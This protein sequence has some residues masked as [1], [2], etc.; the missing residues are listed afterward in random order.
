MNLLKN[1]KAA[2][3]AYCPKEKKEA[4]KPKQIK[5]NLDVNGL[6]TTIKKDP[7]HSRRVSKSPKHHA[8]FTPKTTRCSTFKSML[9]LT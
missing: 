9:H 4:T 8:S 2:K 6:S 3:A 7:T 1:K 5:R